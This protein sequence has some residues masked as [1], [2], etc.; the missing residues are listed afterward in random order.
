VRTP[1]VWLHH[2]ASFAHDV[3]G[4]P[5]RPD[6]IRAL[7]GAMQLGRWYGWERLEAPAAT[8]EALLAVHPQ[9]HLDS[10]EQLCARGGGYIDMDTAAVEATWEAALRAAG[11]AC[12]LVDLLMGGHAST[13]LS[14]LRPPGHHAEAA[15]AMGFCFFNN[16]AVA[17]R[18]AQSQHGVE[19][20]LIF[21]WDVHHGNG[22][23][24]IFWADGSVLFV[25]AHQWPL[26]PGTGAGG[27]VGR[28]EGAGYTVNIPVPPGTGDDAYLSIAR[29]VVCELIGTYAP[30]LVLV[31]AGFDAHRLDPLASCQVSGAGFA[32][33]AVLI[34]LACEAAGVPY[35][36]VLEGGYSLEALIEAIEGLAP[37]LSAETAPDEPAV[38]IHPLVEPVLE[39]MGRYG[40]T[41]RA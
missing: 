8:T 5:E 37:A 1:P 38:A 27:D 20:V 18:W 15:R 31:S 33:M 21:D 14:A 40:L 35:G 34:R 3:P 9:R 24:A 19:R 16:V 17:A 10:L 30:G 23:E 6:R 25:S 41:S 26:Y 28:G 36:F 13:G 32:G 12:S 7:E 29:D 39:R 11:G 2:E 22:T 4:H